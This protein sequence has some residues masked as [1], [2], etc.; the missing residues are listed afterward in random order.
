[1]PNLDGRGPM[2]QGPRTGRGMGWGCCGG[3]RCGRGFGFRRF[4]SSKNDLDTL[5]EQ[6]KMLEQELEAVRK[7]K[8]ALVNLK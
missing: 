1:M 5:E 2:G 7:E 6:E 8:S 3:C 4:F